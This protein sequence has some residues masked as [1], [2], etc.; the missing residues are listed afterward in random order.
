VKKA[1]IF[2]IV[3]F[4]NSWIWSVA[5]RGFWLA[6][7][8]VLASV[9]LFKL[10]QIKSPKRNLVVVS[11]LTLVA[12]VGFQVKEFDLKS[13][14]ETTS[15]QKDVIDKRMRL[16]PNPRIAH[17]FEQRGESIAFYRILANMGEALDI[18]Y[19]FFANHPR[20]RHG[21][22][23]SEKFS[24]LILPLFLMG[25]TKLVLEKRHLFYCLLFAFALGFTLLVYPSEP[26]GFVAVLPFI[27]SS[28]LYSLATY[29]D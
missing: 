13:F 24:P 10:L 19:Y 5:E 11:V 22:T 4:G 27:V 8:C 23:E 7:V 2:F 17:W 12:I 29:V 20:E 28:S 1:L 18:N 26:V 21:V 3:V 16:Y 15:L 6:A 14:V 9:C 25:A